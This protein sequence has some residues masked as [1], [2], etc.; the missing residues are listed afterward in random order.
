MR[1]NVNLDGFDSQNLWKNTG[2]GIPKLIVLWNNPQLVHK[3]VLS[4]SHYR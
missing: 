2:T 3:N 4:L 1:G